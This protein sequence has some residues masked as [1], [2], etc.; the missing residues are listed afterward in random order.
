MTAVSGVDDGGT[1]LAG[2]QHIIRREPATLE[3][4]H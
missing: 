4:N 1:L 2:K 3:D